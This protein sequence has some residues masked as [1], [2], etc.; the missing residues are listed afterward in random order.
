[1]AATRALKHKDLPHKVYQDDFR[2]GRGNALQAAVAS[3][4]GLDLGTVPNFVVL[5]EGYE[6]A[7]E[8][9]CKERG[10]T[11][12]KLKLQQQGDDTTT[13]T[14]DGY[15]GQLCLLRGKS[16]RGDHGHVVVARRIG[17]GES[18]ESTIGVR[19]GGFEMVHDPHPDETFLDESEPFGWCMFFGDPAGNDPESQGK[20]PAEGTEWPELVGKDIKVAERFL[21]D[22]HG[23]ELEVVEVLE[24]SMVTMDYRIDRVRLFVDEKTQT[25]VV[26]VPRLG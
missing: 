11:S 10:G 6:K 8:N 25:T 17:Q 21:R 16:P 5:P 9:F 19:T 24:G 1:M 2:P 14:I 18:G 22:A 12:V 15:E 23:P 3:I 4:F 20:L 26:E 7:I 13:T